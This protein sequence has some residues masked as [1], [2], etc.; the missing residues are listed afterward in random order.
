MEHVHS[1]GCLSRCARSHGI[2]ST[3]CQP[4]PLRHNEPAFP[5][6]SP[7]VHKRARLIHHLSFPPPIP[8]K[9]AMKTFVSHQT[10]GADWA[11]TSGDER[12]RILHWYLR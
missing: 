8:T 3:V 5:L 10:N 2:R 7:F 12:T 1:M 11:E 4:R 9:R 6:A